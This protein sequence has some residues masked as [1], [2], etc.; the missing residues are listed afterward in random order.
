MDRWII[1]CVEEGQDLQGG[2]EG[3]WEEKGFNISQIPNQSG[4]NWGGDP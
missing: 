2:M 3:G 1:N 4:M